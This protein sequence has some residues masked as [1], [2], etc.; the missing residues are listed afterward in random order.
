[1]VEG[2]KR[3]FDK[4]YSIELSPMLSERAANRFKS[5]DHIEIV[6]GDSGKELAKIIEH[7]DQPTL[8]WLDAHFSAGVTARGEIDTP[9]YEEL[10]AILNSR[11]LRH[12]TI[13]DD[14]RYFGTDPAYPTL[15]ELKEF[16]HSK[17]TDVDISVQ[18]DAIR[19]VPK[20]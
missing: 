6:H 10:R 4:I 13:I 9:V 12:I 3:I 14:A 5:L 11:G 19:I 20:Q 8:F 18:N 7:I 1:M 15:E 16:V 2:M 17:R